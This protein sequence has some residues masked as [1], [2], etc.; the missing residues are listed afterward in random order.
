MNA[1]RY[2]RTGDIKTAVSGHE[3]EVLTALGIPY[4]MGNP[5]IDCPYPTHGGINDW[6][7]DAEKSKAFCTC[8]CGD[9]IFDVASKKLAKDF[10]GA[11]VW[12]AETLDRH[13]LIRT[14]TQRGGMS[15]EGLLSRPPEER[16]DRLPRNYLAHR[17]GIEPDAVVMPTTDVVG[18]IALPYYDP[19]SANSDK[20]TLVGKFPCTVWKMIGPDGEFHAH[21]IYIAPNGLGKADLG[22]TS[23][24][25]TRNPK[26]S[27]K[28]QDGK[29]ITGCCVVFGNP[30][31][32]EHIIDAEGIETAAALAYTFRSE[33]LSNKIAVVAAISAVGVE[34][35]KPWPA[36]R[37]ITVAADR[38]EKAEGTKLPSRRGE[39]AAATLAARLAD[40]VPVS[41]ALPGDP[42]E[43]KDWL[44]VLLRD[45]VEAVR[46]GIEAAPVEDVAAIDGEAEIVRLA[47][48]SSPDY[49]QE[50]D[51]AAERLGIRPMTLDELVK[52][53]R[54]RKTVAGAG[55]LF[56][57]VEPW[58]SP[59]D[60]AE[61]LDDINR[62]IRR[63]IICDE[64][65]SVAVALWVTLTWLIDRAQVAPLLVI[66][67]PE[68]R[69]GKTQLLSLVK[70]LVYRPLVASNITPAAVYRVIDAWAPTLLIDE[71][72]TFMG[73]NGEIRG[74]LNSGHTREMAYVIRVEGD[75]HVPKQFSTWGLKAI[76]GIGHR[77]ET[78][79]DRSIVV[80]LRRKRPDETVDRLRN[81]ECEHFDQLNRKLARFAED[82]GEAIASMRPELPSELNDRAQDNWEMPVAIADYAGGHW[83]ETARATALKLSGASNEALSLSAELLTDIRAVFEQRD[84]EKIPT[85]DLLTALNA[86]EEKPW[87][88]F[89]RGRS[90]TARN[91]ADLLREYGISSH[92]MW[93]GSGSCLKGYIWQHFQDAFERYLP[94]EAPNSAAVPT[95]R[96]EN[97]ES[98]QAPDSAGGISVPASPQLPVS[99]P[100]MP[101]LRQTPVLP[102]P[103]ASQPAAA[104]PPLPPRRPLLPPPLPH[105]PASPEPPQRQTPVPPP[106]GALCPV[107]AWLPLWGSKNLNRKSD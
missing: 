62:T 34:A 79:E 56:P 33:L 20:P 19:P 58:S 72:D 27:A 25:R 91:L 95:L 57:V 83:P 31:E 97:Q 76:A 15:A 74:I 90:L 96:D 50:R 60:L 80:E 87:A 37:R 55:G 45:G 9:S 92:N 13:D 98:P 7:W 28:V 67:A 99:A 35:V 100:P 23:N 32:A 85:A 21:R 8:S 22:K 12:I 69:C 44:D 53:E 89:S 82:F 78:I 43:S 16:D 77:S 105:V 101:P 17:L 61:L 51:T 40:V 75:D 1:T 81:A 86:D 46:S 65:D 41:I 47:K 106:Q 36:T 29:S 4:N 64:E 103:P 73:Q 70:C 48:L 68:K 11:K 49:A 104:Q 71:A 59:V 84:C 38:D 2:V 107:S 52:I 94:V 6:R 93:M 66:T 88:T 63:F 42:G 10:E 5:H 24:G 18:L 30:D 54:S 3:H 39:K 102:P 14:S 26:K